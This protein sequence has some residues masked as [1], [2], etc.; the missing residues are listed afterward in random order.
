MSAR[1]DDKNTRRIVKRLVIS[2]KLTLLTPARMGGGEAASTRQA[3]TDMP[4]ARDPQ[5]GLPLLSGSSIAGALRSYLRDW[6]LGYEKPEPDNGTSTTQLLFGEVLEKVRQAD[7]ESRESWLL[8]E[9]ALAQ[10]HNTE[11]RPGV[12][13]DAKTRTAKVDEDER[14]SLYDMEL[15]AA[16]T[17]FPLRLELALPEDA[18]KQARLLAGLAAALGGLESGEIGLGVRKRRGLG[19]CRADAWQVQVYDLR[20]PSGLLAWLERR[21]APDPAAS[22]AD[23]AEKLGADLNL[24]PDLRRRFTLVAHFHLQSSLLI[25]SGSEDPEAPDMVHLKSL[26]QGKQRPVVSGTSLAGALRARALRIART[27]IADEPRAR[28]LINEIFGPD[29]L[30]QKLRRSKDEE[31]YAS[32]MVVR[33]REIHHELEHIQSRVKIDRFTGGAY[34]GA[35]FDQQPVMGKPTREHHLEISIELRQP[36]EAHIGLLLH[37]LKDLWTGDLPLGGEASVGRGRLQGLDAELVLTTPTPPRLD[38]WSL[39]QEDGALV[40]GGN[41]ELLEK[42]AQALGGAL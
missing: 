16:G 5:T 27:R 26:R 36:Q 6:E 10:V 24:L 8:V 12:A 25:R 13:I 40:V 32:R 18:A 39:R 3:T 37:L 42:F 11:T 2:G 14:G 33:E 9:D 4:L 41:P 31:P 22:G 38:R 29:K 34:P 21:P 19:E 15:L 35:L 7:R 1:W 30:E 17:E 28:R 23:I 20:T